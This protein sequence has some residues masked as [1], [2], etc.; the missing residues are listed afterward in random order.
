MVLSYLMKLH[1]TGDSLCD[2]I[3]KLVHVSQRILL[4]VVIALTT[5]IDDYRH[6][7]RLLHH[8]LG[9]ITMRDRGLIKAF[10]GTQV[11]VGI[12]NISSLGRSFSD[13]TYSS[14]SPC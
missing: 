1:L 14:K 3:T 11:R 6:Y 5:R 13:L 4:L 2:D 9:D 12:S 10:H 8:G 7:H